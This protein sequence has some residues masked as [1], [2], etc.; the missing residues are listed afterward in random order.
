MANAILVYELCDFVIEYIERFQIAGFN[1]LQEL[2]REEER[3]RQQFRQALE[4]RKKQAQ[5]FGISDTQRK[6]ALEQIRLHEEAL[7]KGENE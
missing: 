3:S 6:S 2:R 5:E 1:E 7:Q 4:T